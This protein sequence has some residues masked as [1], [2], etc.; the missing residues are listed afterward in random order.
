MCSCVLVHVFCRATVH[1]VC[2]LRGLW[3]VVPPMAEQNMKT[4]PASN[5]FIF[6]SVVGRTVDQTAINSPAW[7]DPWRK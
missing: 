2:A 4:C 7:L 3:L 1:A 6:V 5:G